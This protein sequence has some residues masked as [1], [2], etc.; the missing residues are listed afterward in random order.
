MPLPFC[1]GGFAGCLTL[2]VGLTLGACARPPVPVSRGTA[3]QERESTADREARIVAEVN[4]LRTNPSAYAAHIEARLPYYRG[5]TLRLPGMIAIRTVE[6]AAAA[7]EAVAELRRTTPLSTLEPAAALMAS[8]RDHVRDI[9]PKG[10]LSHDGSGGET[11]ADRIS[12]YAQCWDYIA[13]NISFGPETPRSVVVDLVIDDN[14]RDRGH[15]R[16]LLDPKLRRIGAACGPHSI[17]RTVCVLDFAG[18]VVEKRGV[19]ALGIIPTPAEA[20]R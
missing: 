16:I 10:M 3:E 14:V 12:R 5:T 4:A 2:L 13:E 15:R 7:R 19:S 17:Y 6:G 9:G 18:E 11:L 1:N 20:R 8:A